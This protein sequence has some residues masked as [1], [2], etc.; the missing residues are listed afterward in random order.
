MM[1]ESGLTL[2]DVSDRLGH[3]SIEITSDLYIHVTE[4]RKRE[5]VDQVMKYL[6]N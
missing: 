3:S 1:L 2:K 6:E 5:N 4:K